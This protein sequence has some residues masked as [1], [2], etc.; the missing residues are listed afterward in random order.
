MKTRPWGQGELSVGLDLEH[1]KVI[2]YFEAQG[3]TWGPAELME[4]PEGW[5]VAK[6]DY[7]VSSWW[8][9]FDATMGGDKY[10]SEKFGDEAAVLAYGEW[11]RKAEAARN[12]IGHDE[13]G[14]IADSLIEAFYVEARPGRTPFDNWALANRLSTMTFGKFDI[15]QVMRLLEEASDRYWAERKN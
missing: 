15:K 1:G 8:S 12:A 7:M 13:A 9:A 3:K 10:F 4:I 2:A 14:K 11:R 5:P 6:Y